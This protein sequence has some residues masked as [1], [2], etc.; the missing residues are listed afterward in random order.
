MD[1]NIKI[2]VKIPTDGWTS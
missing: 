1:G 2:N